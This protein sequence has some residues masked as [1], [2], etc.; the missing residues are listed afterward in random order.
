MKLNPDF[1][2]AGLISRGLALGLA[3]GLSAA[4]AGA[5]ESPML[6]ERVQAGTLPPLE[7][8]LPENPLVV[9]PVDRVGD[10]GGTWRSAMVGGS[11]D[12][13]VLRTVSYENLMRWSPDWT[14]VIP[15]IAESVDVSE[16]A[17]SFTFHLRPGMK[18]SDGA[19]FTADDIRF[20]YEDLFLDPQFTPAPSE[21]FINVDGSPVDFEMLDETSFRF[22]FQQPKGLFL[23]YLATARPLDNATVRYPR[24]YL[25][26]F[27]PKYNPE[28]Q[29]EITAAG[30]ADWIGLMVNKA[31][32]WSNPEVPTV[33]PWVF[34]QGYGSG[35]ATR[36]MA[37]RNPFY[38]KVDT[39]GNQLPYIDVRAFDVLSD[40]QVLV[41]KT[42]AGEIDFQ[43]RNLAVAANKP[44][45][46][47]GREQGGFEF[48]EETPASPNYMVM[49]FN[50]NHKDPETRAIFQNKDF[51]IGLSHAM[52]RQEVLDVVWLGQGEVAQTSVMPGSVYYNERLAKQYT[53]F[54]PDA[55]NAH[56]DKVLPNKDSNGVRLGPDG[57]PF[58]FTFAY[59]AANPVFGDALELIAAQWQKVGIQMTPTPL[60]RTLVQTRQDAGELEGVAWERGGGAGQE[61][62]LDPR[63]WF[64]SNLDSYYWAPAWTAWFLGVN[65]E[66]SQVKPEE[67]APAAKRQ[68]ELYGELQASADPEQQIA[69]MNQI[70]D[71][72]AD[73]F[74]TM[75]VAWQASGYG[76]KK[77]NFHN[78]PASMP[79]SWIY[80]TPGPSN[81]EQYF[82]TSN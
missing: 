52:D 14:E 26:T 75:G 36:A 39:E 44:V 68:M 9:T 19:P 45:L 59:S 76:V 11:D 70:L 33:N 49:M 8:R 73:E 40:P 62:V 74:W 25:E 69:I 82:M 13:W 54:D 28:V 23:Q 35:S 42:L 30:Q 7:E 46:F 57:S 32:Y 24:H 17:T 77:T 41:T 79:A 67:P 1:R 20:W 60:D 47:Q 38:F 61:V 48:F 55:A 66:T 78:V 2:L 3:V 64:P 37:E 16:D 15:N 43:D 21:P 12:G 81:P 50:L 10:Y 72:A 22:T 6:A 58:V 31:N 53:E 18:W 71:I 80:P 34:T 51:R 4:P 5:G 63:W 65:P 27:H 29:Q 56:L